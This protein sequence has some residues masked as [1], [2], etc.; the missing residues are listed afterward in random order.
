MKKKL[1]KSLLFSCTLA[2][3]VPTL[4]FA[5]NWR[6]DFNGWWYQHENGNYPVNSWMNQNG[7]WYHF[8]EAG[9]MQTGWIFDQGT[10]YYLKPSGAMASDEWIGNYYLNASGAMAVNTW[11]GNY[12]VGSDGAWI[13][14]YSQSQWILDSNGW[15]YRH[16][17]GSYTSSN[18]E[19]I[20][21]TW[22]YFNSAGYIVTG[23]Q[24]ING[25]WYYFDLSGAMYANRWVGNY[26]L[27]SSGAM[28]VNTTTPDGYWV[29]SD[30][31]WIPNQ[32]DGTP[33]T[34]GP[35]DNV[36]ATYFWTK[37]GKSYHASRDCP[38]LSRSKNIDSGSFDK[39]FAAGKTDPCNIC[40][41]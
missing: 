31:A 6:Q 8:N 4:A 27:G 7:T 25:A 33:T 24:S 22:Y 12:Y 38:T 14:G 17:D 30:G 2:L 36:S 18:W 20:H 32:A 21:G 28:L 9:Y 39:A 19:N 23:W 13:P 41:K 15:W 3:T 40:I 37:N 35:E 11:I 5:G 29:G 16:A 1:F 34:P 26:Y 10:W